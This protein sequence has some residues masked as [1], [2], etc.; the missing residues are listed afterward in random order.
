MRETVT[1]KEK[2]VLDAMRIVGG[3]ESG[4]MLEMK[5]FDDI[6]KE[7]NIDSLDLDN[8]VNAVLASRKGNVFEADGYQ[9][10]LSHEF[11]QAEWDVAHQ[12]ADVYEKRGQ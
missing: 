5:T 4:R 2:A 3:I 7:N 10:N 9:K 12:I 8:A 6:A 1:E 11:T